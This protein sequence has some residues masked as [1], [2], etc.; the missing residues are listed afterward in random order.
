MLAMLCGSEQELFVPVLSSQMCCTAKEQGAII[1]TAHRQL[2]M[3]PSYSLAVQHIREVSTG[4][5]I[6]WWS[7]FEYGGSAPSIGGEGQGFR[8]WGPGA[9]LGF[10]HDDCR[11]EALP[12]PVVGG[13][14][15]VQ[16]MAVQAISME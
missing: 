3:I 4:T 1:V 8:L 13:G 9:F 16:A 5:N 7:T 11:A 2:M 14:R 12:H 6:T 10:A 15:R